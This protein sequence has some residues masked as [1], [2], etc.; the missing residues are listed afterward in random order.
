[1]EIIGDNT[2]VTSLRG[3][4]KTV[5]CRGEQRKHWLELQ[6]VD[7]NNSPV[8]GLN[9]RLKYHP[10]A[11]S[12]FL[13]LQDM[14]GIS[15][16]ETRKLPGGEHAWPALISLLRKKLKFLSKDV[17]VVVVATLL[18]G[19]DNRPDR[20]LTEL[21]LKL[22]RSIRLQTLLNDTTPRPGCSRY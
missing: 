7:E 3:T 13:A 17:V 19:C 6:F 21:L 8:T 10:L 18:T 5:Q 20:M 4:Y 12:V 1:M 2:L 15:L 22:F 16:T 9:V 14:Q 11:S